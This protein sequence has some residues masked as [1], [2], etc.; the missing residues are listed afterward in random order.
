MKRNKLIIFCGI[1]TVNNVFTFVFFIICSKEFYRK[2]STIFY[3][4][5]YRMIIVKVRS[6]CVWWKGVFYHKNYRMIIVKVRSVWWRGV[7]YHKNYQMIIVKVRSRCVWWKGVSK[8]ICE[9]YDKNTQK[10]KC[11]ENYVQTYYFK[12]SFISIARHSI[13]YI[14]IE[15]IV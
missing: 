8:L 3:H 14:L 6:R 2:F 1:G 9:I 13:L 5:N 4:K 12:F 7:F 10:Y 15:F 11:P